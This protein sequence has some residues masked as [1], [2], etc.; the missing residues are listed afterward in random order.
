MLVHHLWP[1][2]ILNFRIVLFSC[3]MLRSMSLVCR[4]GFT[5]AAHLRFL[6]RP[7]RN[8]FAVPQ[9]IV[10]GPFHELELHDQCGLARAVLAHLLRCESS[11]PTAAS[12]LPQI[13]NGAVVSM[14]T[15]KSFEELLSRCRREAITGASRLDE[16]VAFVIAR[17][18]MHRTLSRWLPPCAD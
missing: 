3:M 4:M 8:K 10:A 9:V 2:A 16:F 18:P 15:A 17:L 7:Q 6:I 14:Q 13:A 12:W 5:L 1:M 11:T